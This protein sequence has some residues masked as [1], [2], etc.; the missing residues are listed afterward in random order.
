MVI[1]KQVDGLD[2]RFFTMERPLVNNPLSKW[3]VLIRRGSY[4][5]AAEDR[6][7]EYGPVYDLWTYIDPGRDYIVDGSNNE[8]IKDQEN[9]DDHKQE[10][11]S[12][13]HR[14]PRRLRKGDK[15]ALRQI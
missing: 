3:L 5:A 2:T 14:N 15:R 12:D 7:W 1:H 11:L 9:L 4:Q 8:G 13:Q 6:R 10:V